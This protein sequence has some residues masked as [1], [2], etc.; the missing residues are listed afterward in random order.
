[1]LCKTTFYFVSL[2]E[3]M[4]GSTHFVNP[5]EIMV[6]GPRADMGVV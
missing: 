2:R 5:G 4:I 6:Q 1:M 3:K